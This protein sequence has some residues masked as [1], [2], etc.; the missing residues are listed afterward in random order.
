[1]LR[2]NCF[3]KKYAFLRKLLMLQKCFT[4]WWCIIRWLMTVYKLRL[5]TASPWGGVTWALRAY[6]L[7][8][9]IS[10]IYLWYFGPTSYTLK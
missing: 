10:I 8:I 1:M 7:Y 2:K 3:I 5:P 4:G 9:K 6:I